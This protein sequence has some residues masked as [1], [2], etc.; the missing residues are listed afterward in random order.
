MAWPNRSMFPCDFNT[1]LAN[2]P[3]TPRIAMGKAKHSYG[4]SKSCV[5]TNVPRFTI[6]D[7]CQD[8]EM[9][10]VE[11]TFLN[12]TEKHNTIPQIYS[13]TQQL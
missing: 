8:E 11:H 1:Q 5:T 7:A 12:K 13:C 2:P 9:L 6:N 4:Q 3:C 10:L